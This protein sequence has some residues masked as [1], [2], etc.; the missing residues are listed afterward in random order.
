[1]ALRPSNRI[2]ISRL[3]PW[4]GGFCAAEFWSSQARLNIKRQW[5]NS[6]T[7]SSLGNDTIE[8][9]FVSFVSFLLTCINR[10]TLFCPLSPVTCPL[11]PLPSP[12]CCV[13]FGANYSEPP[14][15]AVHHSSFASLHT[16]LHLH[17]PQP[18]LIPVDQTVVAPWV[19]RGSAMER[20]RKGDFN[21]VLQ[22]KKRMSTQRG[23]ETRELVFCK[24][25]S[26]LHKPWLTLCIVN[27]FLLWLF[28]WEV[29]IDK[30]TW[31]TS[32]MVSEV[33]ICRFTIRGKAQSGLCFYP[34]KQ[35]HS[36]THTHAHTNAQTT[37]FA[38]CSALLRPAL[39]CLHKSLQAT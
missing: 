34:F 38:I 33:E 17:L 14:T 11:S 23:E 2:D 28:G 31:G 13:L 8:K 24:T 35:T 7:S 29:L 10:Q 16:S 39:K 9:A 4:G 1:M 5:K 27:F 20:E 12:L 30:M 37:T 32:D 36:H 21:G 15:S 18:V 3:L 25:M 22:C 19:P 6:L 26:V